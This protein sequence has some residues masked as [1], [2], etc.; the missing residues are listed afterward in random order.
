MPSSSLVE[1]LRAARLE[2]ARLDPRGGMPLCPP[3]PATAEAIS[4]AERRIGR[5]LPPSYREF[6]AVHDGWPQFFQGAALLGARQL[7][8]GAFVEVARMVLGELSDADTAYVVPFGIDAEAEVILAWD[9]SRPGADG[10]VDVLFWVNEIGVTVG[11]FW[12]VLDLARDIVDAAVV[13]KRAGGLRPQA[14]R[15]AALG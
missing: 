13:D 15:P 5:P 7:A 10:E 14:A 3:P 9:F 12:A 1:S 4:H 2:L 6:L 8:R 11:S